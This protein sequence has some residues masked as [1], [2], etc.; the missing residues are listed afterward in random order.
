MPAPLRRAD[1]TSAPTYATNTRGPIR[2]LRASDFCVP[3]PVRLAGHVVPLGPTSTG[4]V[5]VLGWWAVACS[6]APGALLGFVYV[7]GACR[8]KLPLHHVGRP[9]SVHADTG[10][11]PTAVGV[12]RL[13]SGGCA[14]RAHSDGCCGGRASSS[15][16]TAKRPHMP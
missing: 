9:A 6:T 5:R 2:H 7:W 8:H 14:N 12:S 1:L 11:C 13:L 4:A 3:R 15:D 10:G 16:L